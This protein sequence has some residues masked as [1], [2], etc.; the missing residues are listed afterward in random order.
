MSDRKGSRCDPKRTPRLHV[1]DRRDLL[2]GRQLPSITLEA[3]PG[4][5]VDLRRQWRRSS[6]VVTTLPGIPEPRTLAG[7]TARRI[8]AWRQLDRELPGYG[9]GLVFLTSRSL[10]ER[11]ESVGHLSFSHALFSDA[12]LLLADALPLTTLRTEHGRDYREIT[13]L[14]TNGTIAEVFEHSPDPL[15]DILA[16]MHLVRRRQS[17]D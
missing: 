5:Q 4:I 11:H 10:A 16:V 3:W 2:P 15:A 17:H 13:F 12:G 1:V 8:Q 14:V 9:Y 6:V 7:R